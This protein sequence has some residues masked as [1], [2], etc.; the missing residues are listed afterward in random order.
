MRRDVENPVE[1]ADSVKELRTLLEWSIWQNI[2]EDGTPGYNKREA[3][4]NRRLNSIVKLC[5]AIHGNF[6]WQYE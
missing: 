4:G 2:D 3:T 1:I 5:K 6:K